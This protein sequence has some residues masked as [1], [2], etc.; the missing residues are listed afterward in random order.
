MLDDRILNHSASS[1]QAVQLTP[2]LRIRFAQCVRTHYQTYPQALA[3][4]AR[5]AILPPTVANHRSEKSES[6]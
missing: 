6:L 2:E 4:Q 1:N 3:L 5:G